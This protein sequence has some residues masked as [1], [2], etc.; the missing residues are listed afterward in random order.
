M[1]NKKGEWLLLNKGKIYVSSMIIAL[2]V[3]SL[4][5]RLCSCQEALE[6]DRPH[7]AN[8]VIEYKEKTVERIQ[9]RV[10]YSHDDSPA[11]DVVVEIYQ[12]T[13]EDKKLK[14]HE[15]ALQRQRRT[16]CVTRKDGSF[17]FNDLPSGNYLMRAGT[18]SAN[19]G[20]NEVYIRVT[21]DRRWWSRWFRPSKE[22]VLGLRPGT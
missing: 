18:R 22:I 19:A 3:G 16:A 13:S 8:E 14:T 15:F 12:I 20:M 11:D 4:P 1:I 2:V 10:V 5:A 6:P 9:G 17:C 21:L 7:G